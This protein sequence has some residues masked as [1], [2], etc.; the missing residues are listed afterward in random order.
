MDKCKFCKIGDLKQGEG[1]YSDYMKC[2][3]CNAYQPDKVVSNSNVILPED[4]MDAMMCE[5]CQ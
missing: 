4:P 2:T 5:S 1:L 3:S